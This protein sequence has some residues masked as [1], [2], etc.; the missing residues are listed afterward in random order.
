MEKLRSALAKSKEKVAKADLDSKD[1]REMLDIER[2]EVER[3]KVGRKLW[4]G[5]GGSSGNDH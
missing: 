1:L 5:G 3:L 4:N 2:R